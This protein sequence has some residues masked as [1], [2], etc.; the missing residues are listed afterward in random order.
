MT[1]QY[2]TENEIV[3]DELNEEAMDSLSSKIEDAINSSM[4]SFEDDDYRI[5]LLMVLLSFSAQVAEDLTVIPEEFAKLSGNIYKDLL[6]EEIEERKNHEQE[7]RI[8]TDKSLL[9]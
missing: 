6:E 7:H 5:E 8:S 9:N 1:K 3:I 2:A 4:K